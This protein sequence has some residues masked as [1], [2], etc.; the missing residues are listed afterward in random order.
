MRP[1]ITVQHDVVNGRMALQELGDRRLHQQGNPRLREARAQ[2]RERRRRQHRV[3]DPV[4][5]PDQDAPDRSRPGQPCNTP[6][7]HL[8][9]SLK[10]DALPVAKA[11]ASRERHE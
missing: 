4:R 9:S 7:V 10:G 6:R 1:R 8:V 5:A 2:G 3:A 11:H